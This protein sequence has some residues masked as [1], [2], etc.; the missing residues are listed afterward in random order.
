LRNQRLL[1]VSDGALQYVPFMTLPLLKDEGGRM[2]DEKKKQKSLHPS[3]LIL[4]PLITRHEIVVL[5]S[6]STLAVL[7][8]ETANRPAATKSLAIFADPVFE[9]QDERVKKAEAKTEKKADAASADASR[10]LLIK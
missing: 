7:R 5:P 9:S 4:Q 6:A 1:I 8:R 3:S 2:K 10:V